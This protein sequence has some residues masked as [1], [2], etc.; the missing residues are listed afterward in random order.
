MLKMIERPRRLYF[1]LTGRQKS[2]NSIG[3]AEPAFRAEEQKIVYL[4]LFAPK[5]LQSWLSFVLFTWW[6]CSLWPSPL[7]LLEVDHQCEGLHQGEYLDLG[8]QHPHHCQ[9]ERLHCLLSQVLVQVVLLVQQRLA[10]RSPPRTEAMLV[11]VPL[12]PHHH[13]SASSRSNLISL[14]L[15]LLSS[16][17]DVPELRPSVGS[18]ARNVLSSEASTSATTKTTTMRLWSTCWSTATPA[19]S[20]RAWQQLWQEQL[21]AGSPL[22]PDYF[23]AG[24]PRPQPSWWKQ[25]RGAGAASDRHDFGR[26]PPLWQLRIQT[27]PFVDG[28]WAKVHIAVTWSGYCRLPRL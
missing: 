10:L 24:D 7:L 13:L 5:F 22:P 27:R 2:G 4:A 23:P 20:W 26:P 16:C 8:Q 15:L 19:A 11:L 9:Q 17:H 25:P 3:P 18:P 28:T 14:Q 21:S 12:K 1:R 6:D